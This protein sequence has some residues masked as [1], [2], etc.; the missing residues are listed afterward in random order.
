MYN[1]ISICYSLCD[2]MTMHWIGQRKREK[3]V[4]NE[5]ASK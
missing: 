3:A 1:F 2:P 4:K 5:F